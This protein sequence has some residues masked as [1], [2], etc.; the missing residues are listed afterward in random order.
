VL[1]FLLVGLCCSL[2]VPAVLHSSEPI[3]I[4]RD[5]KSLNLLVDADWNVK[6]SDFGLSR[7]KAL[8]SSGLMTAQCGTFHWMAPEVIAGHKYTEKADVYSFGIDMWELLTRAIPFTGL[9]PMQVKCVVTSTFHID[10]RLVAVF[11]RSFSQ[12]AMAVLTRGL[13]P[14]IP[15]DCPRDYALLMEACWQTEPELRPTFIEITERLAHML[16]R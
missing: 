8:T 2:C 15:P 11:V 7:F 9:Q 10:S 1:I 13:R 3:I 5:L 12:V 6:V 14:A 4:H 16:D